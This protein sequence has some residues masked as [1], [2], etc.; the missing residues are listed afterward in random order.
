MQ[1]QRHVGILRVNAR[2]PPP[3]LAQR[4]TRSVLD[5]QSAEMRVQ[6]PA[7]AVGRGRPRRAAAVA[8]VLTRVHQRAAPGACPVTWPHLLPVARALS[9]DDSGDAQCLLRRGHEALPRNGSRERVE[10]GLSE[11]ILCARHLRHYA[12]R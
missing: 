5:G 12:Q 2:P 4:V 1:Q 8:C 9:A 6:K 7:A 3:R 10:I 11:H